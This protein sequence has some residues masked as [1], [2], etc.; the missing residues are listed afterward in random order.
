MELDTVVILPDGRKGII[1]S[2]QYY[3]D[4]GISNYWNGYFLDEDGH[5]TTESFGGYNNGR[6][7]LEYK[8]KYAIQK[9][10]IF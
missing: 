2:G 9:R 6:C 8:G 4:N 3:G 1:T 7:W 5:I 10:I